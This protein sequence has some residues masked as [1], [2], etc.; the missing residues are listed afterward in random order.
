MIC[1]AS[2]DENTDGVGCRGSNCASVRGGGVADSDFTA[3]AVGSVSWCFTLVLGCSTFLVNL[4]Y[5]VGGIS[6][7]GR[8]KLVA[9]AESDA[10]ANPVRSVGGCSAFILIAAARR[11]QRGT[12]FFVV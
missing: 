1:T 7:R 2:L 8:G 5:S 12:D 9:T 4:T 10:F 11:S 3:L 6:S